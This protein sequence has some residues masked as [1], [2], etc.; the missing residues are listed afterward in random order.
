MLDKAA[1]SVVRILECSVSS[2]SYCYR[3]ALVGSRTS[4]CFARNFCGPQQ[5]DCSMPR[6]VV[7]SP[8]PTRSCLTI[9]RDTS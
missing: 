8:C 3:P 9:A 6:V 5:A 2:C 1:C 7:M 4:C